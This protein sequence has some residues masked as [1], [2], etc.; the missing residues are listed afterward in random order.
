MMQG[1][2]KQFFFPDGVRASKWIENCCFNVIV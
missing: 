1:V 2:Q